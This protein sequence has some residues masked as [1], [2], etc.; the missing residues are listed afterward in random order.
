M[1]KLELGQRTA[2][3]ELE[4]LPGYHLVCEGIDCDRKNLADPEIIRSFLENFPDEI[5]MT[6]ITVPKVESYESE[7]NGRVISGLVMIAE[8]HISIHAFCDRKYLFADIF[9]CRSFDPKL[10]LERLKQHFGAQEVNYQFIRRSQ[11]NSSQ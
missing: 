6:K 5:G 10:A 9:S 4:T 3:P 11:P 8:S 1:N 7:D 2:P